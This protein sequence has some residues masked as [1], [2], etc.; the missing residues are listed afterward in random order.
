MWFL[1]GDFLKGNG[2][3]SFDALFASYRHPAVRAVGMMGGALATIVD[4]GARRSLG[5]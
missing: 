3:V 5:P 1:W 4:Q 2:H